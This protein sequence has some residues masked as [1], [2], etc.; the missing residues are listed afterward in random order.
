MGWV[1]REFQERTVGLFPKDLRPNQNSTRSILTISGRDFIYLTHTTPYS[2]TSQLTKV[3]T[4]H[5]TYCFLDPF[6]L[7]HL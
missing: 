3:L 6:S 7:R 1:R 2:H 4:Q 5:H